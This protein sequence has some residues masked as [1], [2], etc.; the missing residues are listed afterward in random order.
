MKVGLIN[1]DHTLSCGQVFRWSKGPE[2][3]RGF[4]RNRPVLVRQA[5]GQVEV[6]G[7]VSEAE[8]LSYFRSGDD[9]DEILRDISK[10]AYISD[11]V[12]RY[13]GLRLVRQDPW[14][15]AASYIL[16]TYASITRIEGMIDAV[17]RTFGAEVSSGR[18]SFPTPREVIENEEA[19]ARCRLGFR[20]RRF[21]EFAGR[22]NDGDLDFERLKA[23]SYR[24]CVA[25]LRRFEGIGEKVADCIAL[26]SLDHLESFP[27]D[28]R[29]R[30][31]MSRQ[32]GASGSYR[33]IGEAAREYFGR[34][35][36]Y[37]QEYIYASEARKSPL[38]RRLIP[39]AGRRTEAP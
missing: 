15:C 27:V 2:G 25:E 36:G 30:R 3:W 5:D 37:A 12:R 1:L 10:D 21:V 33:K 11:L 29:I 7:D 9:L 8:V 6:D 35:A 28:V 32:Y 26:F 20:C 19:A 34:Y 24:D 23:V 38:G 18:Y 22:V 39:S 17:C 13:R 31:A 14:E 16:A 4:I